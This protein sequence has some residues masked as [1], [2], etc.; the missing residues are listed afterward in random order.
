MGRGWEEDGRGNTMKI[1]G[2]EEHIAI[3]IAVSTACHHKVV[4]IDQ[5]L[6]LFPGLL[7]QL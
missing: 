2:I 1:P 5:F 4:G 7:P 6:A 3:N